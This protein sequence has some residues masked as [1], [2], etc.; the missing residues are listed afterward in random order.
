M[1]IKER[2][3]GYKIRTVLNEG[4]DNLPSASAQRLAS[5]RKMALSRKKS[6]VGVALFQSKLAVQAGHFFNDP[7]SWLAR[8]GATIPV[9]VLVVGLIGIYE[10]EEAQR[11]TDI[12]ELDAAVL[13]DEL[14]LS[15]YTDD[16]FNAFLAQR[17]EAQ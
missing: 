17:T 9:I 4:I 16:G 5:A 8:I 12:A 3:F 7:F 6:P 2:D 14:P 13:A 10:A 11:I 1:T 15:A